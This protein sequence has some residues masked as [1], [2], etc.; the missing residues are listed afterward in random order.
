MNVALKTYDTLLKRFSSDTFEGKALRYFDEKQRNEILLYA[1]NVFLSI[2][3]IDK[4]DKP[5][6]DYTNS[7]GLQVQI[8]EKFELQYLKEVK[9]NQGLLRLLENISFKIERLA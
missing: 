2:P 9:T 6:E 8:A 5:I 7:G 1:M 3:N 4:N